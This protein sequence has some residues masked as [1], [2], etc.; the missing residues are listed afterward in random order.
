MWTLAASL[1]SQSQMVRDGLY[2]E[3]RRLLYDLELDTS[4]L[5]ASSL[6]YAQAWI[7]VAIYEWTSNDYTRSLMSAGRAFRCVQLLRLHELD[8]ASSWRPG[9]RTGSRWSRGA[10]R[11]GSRTPSIASRPSMEGC[12]LPLAQMRY[13]LSRKTGRE[14][15][16]ADKTLPN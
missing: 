13:Y 14:E 1:S 10:A 4:E 12:R 6:E 15:L 5:G 7:L 11:S 3:A 16:N 9:R 2:T 8:G